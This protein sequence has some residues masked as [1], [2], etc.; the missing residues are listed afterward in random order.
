MEIGYILYTLPAGSPGSYSL[1][2]TG[3]A[4]LGLS[5][6][7][8]EGLNIAPSLQPQVCT[9]DSYRV[10]LNAVNP[11]TQIPWMSTLTLA[12]FDLDLS[13]EP[14]L[15][16]P[17]TPWTPHPTQTDP[18]LHCPFST[19]SLFLH[20]RQTVSLLKAV[21]EEVLNYRLM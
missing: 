21:V 15:T 9:E 14:I 11:A 1:S 18:C 17:L 19:R 5:S 6:L 20:L 8:E 12:P 10:G 4:Y 16:L 2:H 3:D 7:N 13:S